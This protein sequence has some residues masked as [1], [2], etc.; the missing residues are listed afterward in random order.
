[1]LKTKA[2]MQEVEVR[3]FEE[4]VGKSGN[5]YLVVKVDDMQGDRSEILDR[6]LS[7]AE[8]YKRGTVGDLVIKLDIGKYSNVEIV[9]F[10]IKEK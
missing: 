7:R 6:D 3:G 9:D 5:K 1:M 10:K 2:V 4:K 8:Y